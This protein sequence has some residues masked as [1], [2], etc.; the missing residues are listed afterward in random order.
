MLPP[1]RSWWVRRDMAACV[2][3]DGLPRRGAALDA[4]GGALAGV[5]GPR[6]VAAVCDRERSE[7]RARGGAGR[8]PEPQGGRRGR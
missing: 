8:D 6:R 7:G 3:P 2:R 4:R 5:E 1:V